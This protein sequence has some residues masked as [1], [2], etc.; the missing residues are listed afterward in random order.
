ML[1]FLGGKFLSPLPGLGFHGR[2]TQRSRAGLLSCGPPGLVRQSRS[3]S[4]S[5][6]VIRAIRGSN[7]LFRVIVVGA[8]G[9][10]GSH[11]CPRLSK[12]HPADSIKESGG[13]GRTGGSENL[14]I[15]PKT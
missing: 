13:R 6:C 8:D 14:E 10:Y 3:K 2:G 4:L 12:G 15:R 9:F 7:C 5:I 11:P 1:A